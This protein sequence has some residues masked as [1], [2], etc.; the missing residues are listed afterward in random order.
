MRHLISKSYGALVVL[1]NHRYDRGIGVRHVGVPVVS[2]GNI[3]TGGTGKTPMIIAIAEQMVGWGCRV[4]I[5]ARGYKRR[6]R[7]VVVVSEGTGSRIPVTDSGDELALI[8]ERVPRA[9]VIAASDRYA[10]AHVACERFNADVIL[11]DDGFQHRALA[12]SLDIVMVDAA[13]LDPDNDLLPVGTLREPRS[14]LHR[15]HILCAIGVEP[16]AIKPYATPGAHIV[17]ASVHLRQWRTLQGEPTIPP[18]GS[19]LAVSAIANPRRFVNMLATC[20]SI[21]VVEHLAWRDHHWYRQADVQHIIER[22]SSYAVRYVVTTEKDAVK[23]RAF[24]PIFA[25][26]GCIVTVARISLEFNATDEIVLESM[27][28]NLCATS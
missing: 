2:V 14:S 1:R 15:A 18:I 23:L 21:H 16:A 22:A 9:C 28:S 27:L 25:L 26:A 11:L 5:V 10:G 24:A 3:T 8:A 19:V 7:G 12:R 13:T 6:R 20:S 17:E 4:A